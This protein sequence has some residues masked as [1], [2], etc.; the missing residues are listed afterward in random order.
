MLFHLLAVVFRNWLNSGD[1][2]D[3]DRIFWLCFLLFHLSGLHRYV[4]KVRGILSEIAEPLVINL[5]QA[6]MLG[7]SKPASLKHMAHK[8]HRF[9]ASTVQS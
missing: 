9:G 6:L 4:I 3:G 8:A 2:L 5:E 1:V 7:E